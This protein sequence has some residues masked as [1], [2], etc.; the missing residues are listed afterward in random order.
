M[1]PNNRMYCNLKDNKKIS[2]PR[3]Y[4]QKLYTDEEREEIGQA[5]LRRIQAHPDYVLNQNKNMVQRLERLQ[6]ANAQNKNRSQQNQK[7]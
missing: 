3:Y 5:T 1:I 2:M 7:I 6:Q 4:K